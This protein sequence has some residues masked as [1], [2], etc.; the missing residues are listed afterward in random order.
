MAL[1]MVEVS[2]ATERVAGVEADV[3]L[4]EVVVPSRL[5]VRPLTTP[6]TVL[7]A[8]VTGMPSTVR[9]ASVPWL[10]RVSENAGSPV[11]ATVPEFEEAIER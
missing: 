8:L 10:A 5:S 7:E 9:E 6:V 4:D 2:A 1:V 11:T 3:E